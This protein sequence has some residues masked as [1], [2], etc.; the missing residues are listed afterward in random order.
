MYGLGVV[1]RCTLGRKRFE[2]PRLQQLGPQL[3]NTGFE[4]VI[5]AV[6]MISLVDKWWFNGGN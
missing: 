6:F 1:Q 4:I 2:P 5:S 3:I